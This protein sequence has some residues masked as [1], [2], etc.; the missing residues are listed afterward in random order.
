MLAIALALLAQGEVQFKTSWPDGLKEAK[1]AQGKLAVLVF[2]TP[3]RRDCKRFADEALKHDAVVAA[4]NRHVAVKVNPLGTDDE[5]KLWQE[6]GQ[7]MPPATIVFAPDGQKLT[8]I[9]TGS[10]KYY[11]EALDAAGPAY[12]HKIIPAREALAKDPNQPDKLAMLGEAYLALDNSAESSNNYKA[13][14]E[15]MLKKG[16]KSGAL[17]LLKGQMAAYYGKKWYVH[18]RACCRNVLEL[19]PSNGTKLC[20]QA[21]WVLGMAD[22]AEG[23]WQDCISGLSAACDR[24][25]DSDILDKMMFTLG[26][27]HMY[28]KEKEKAIA[29]FEKI[30]AKFPDSETAKLAETQANKLR[31]K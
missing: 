25:K 11:A 18:A 20:P 16:D 6:Q 19:D 24:F 21:A 30:M 14:V 5:N 15:L 22:C 9:L 10:G 23:K 3:D 2:L 28:A 27:A 29:V 8:V 17:E 12:F 4:L 7:P 13:A 31:S 1:A 26:S